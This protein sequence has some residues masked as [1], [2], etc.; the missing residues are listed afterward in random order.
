MPGTEATHELEVVLMYIYTVC[1]YTH[2]PRFFVYLSKEGDRMKFDLSYAT[3]EARKCADY[4]S[5]VLHSTSLY[6]SMSPITRICVCNF[7]P[8]S[9]LITMIFKLIMLL[10]GLCFP[11][12]KWIIGC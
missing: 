3:H 9:M 7:T 2:T 10:F 8:H 11:L 5:Q 1:I 6:T 4:L 12:P